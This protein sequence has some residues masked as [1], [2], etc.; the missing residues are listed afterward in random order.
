MTVEFFN[1]IAVKT[2]FGF[3]LE[4]CGGID[5]RVRHRMSEIQQ[6]RFVLVRF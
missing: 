3:A 2:A 1:H 5:N 4:F 6:E